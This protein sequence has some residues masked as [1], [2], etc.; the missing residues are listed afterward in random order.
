M[1]G[2]CVNK[3]GIPGL[4]ASWL[5]V[6][7][8]AEFEAEAGFFDT[9]AVDGVAGDEVKGNRTFRRCLPV[10]RVGGMNF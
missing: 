5:L 2:G 4:G 1:G 8:L 10:A 6:M 3:A 7:I 9:R